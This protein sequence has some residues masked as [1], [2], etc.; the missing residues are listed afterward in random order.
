MFHSL[1]DTAPHFLKK[2]GIYQVYHI[3]YQVYHI[4]VDNN[5]MTGV[6]GG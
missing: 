6:F 2:L 5:F 3:H 1:T 4:L